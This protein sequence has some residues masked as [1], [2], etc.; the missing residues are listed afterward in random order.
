[1]GRLA[2]RRWER[3][4]DKPGLGRQAQKAPREQ[5]RN[6][7]GLQWGGQKGTEMSS[8]LALSLPVAPEVRLYIEYL[9]PSVTPS[10]HPKKTLLLQM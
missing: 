6:S 4:R 9:T 2:E 8:P 5:W 7:E 3:D 10:L 1:M